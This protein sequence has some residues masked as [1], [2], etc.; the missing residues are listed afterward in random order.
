V[1]PVVEPVELPGGC[2]LVEPDEVPTPESPGSGGPGQAAWRA[3][4]KRPPIAA[5][6]G[7]LA[8]R[9]CRVQPGRSIIG[10]R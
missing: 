10:R 2:P 9:T 3:R 4:R 7:P 6:I 8:L 1:L 5:R